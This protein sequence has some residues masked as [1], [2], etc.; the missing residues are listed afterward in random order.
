MA[1]ARSPDTEVSINPRSNTDL[2]PTCLGIIGNESGRL[3]CHVEKT[4]NIL[5][6]IPNANYSGWGNQ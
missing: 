5:G 6:G 4:S 1:T 2:L 3:A